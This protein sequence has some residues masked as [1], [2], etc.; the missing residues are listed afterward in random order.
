MF[1]GEPKGE[2]NNVSDD[3]KVS[4]VLDEELD[5]ELI[6]KISAP[7]NMEDNE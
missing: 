1:T 5:F 3:Y 4:E 2:H 7:A 6:D